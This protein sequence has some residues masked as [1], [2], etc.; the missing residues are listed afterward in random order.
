MSSFDRLCETFEQMDGKDFTAIFN[1][2]SVEVLN[3]LVEMS[4]ADGVDAYLHFILAAVAADG[5]LA[6]EEFALIKPIFDRDAGK[7]VT[8]EE[9]VAMFKEM[10][11]DDPAAYKDVIDTMVDIIGAFDEGLKDDIVL[12]SLMVCAVDGHVSEEEK[13]WI[14]QLIEP[15]TIQVDAMDV[16]DEFLG[17]AGVF[18]LGTCDGDKPRMRVLGLKIRL[19]GGLFFAVG[20]FKDVY[21][22]LRANPNCEILATVGPEF[23][24]WDG[25]A[26]FVEDPRLKPIVANMMPDLIKMYDEMGWKLAFF[27]LQDDTAEIVN[28]SNQKKKLF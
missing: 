10:G 7:D 15:L 23:L 26:V 21:K 17:K 14:R 1:A 24:R 16:I 5:T 18:T 27:T 20:S 11:L 4:G 2:K 12:L 9:A 19:D 13:D 3:A 8:Y 6:E 25:K 22:Q 28:V